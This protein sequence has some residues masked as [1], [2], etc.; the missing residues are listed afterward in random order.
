MK[1]TI[2]ILSLVLLGACHSSDDN[3]KIDYSKVSFVGKTNKMGEPVEKNIQECVVFSQG[4][5]EKSKIFQA[6][7]QHLDFHCR[8]VNANLDNVEDMND[9]KKLEEKCRN[10]TDE[11]YKLK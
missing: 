8:C 10:W 11:F 9:A 1:K 5:I 7:S 6:D 4:E 2:L 3:F